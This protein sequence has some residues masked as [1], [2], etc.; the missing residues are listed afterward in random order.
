MS[1]NII[2]VH[3]LICLSIA[4]SLSTIFMRNFCEIILRFSVKELEQVRLVC[5][6]YGE[7]YADGDYMMLVGRSNL[8]CIC[9][10]N[11][12]GKNNFNSFMLF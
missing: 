8:V 7:S 2:I 11:D 6:I 9:Q 12:T 1:Q 10:A 3:S 5:N 4:N